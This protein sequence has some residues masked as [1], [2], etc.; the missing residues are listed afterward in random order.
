MFKKSDA[1]LCLIENFLCTILKFRAH[2]SVSCCDCLAALKRRVTTR[3][4]DKGMMQS[5]MLDVDRLPETNYEVLVVDLDCTDSVE[6]MQKVQSSVTLI[7]ER[8]SWY[9]NCYD[10]SQFAAL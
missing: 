7:R 2:I 6:L 1:N 8:E 9:G 3:L 4:R 5:W 10:R